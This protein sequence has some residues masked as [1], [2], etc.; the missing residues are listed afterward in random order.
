MRR[1]A[2]GG[3]RELLDRFPAAFFP[4]LGYILVTLSKSTID[5]D[6][7]VRVQYRSVARRI[8]QLLSEDYFQNSDGSCK[9]DD[10]KSGRDSHRSPSQLQQRKTT[11][12]QELNT[13]ELNDFLPLAKRL[14][15]F[16]Q[17]LGLQLRASLT[18][19]SPDIRCDALSFLEALI[20]NP[21]VTHPLV[22]KIVFACVNHGAG[23]KTTTTAILPQPFVGQTDSWESEEHSRKTETTLFLFI[24]ELYSKCL[25]SMTSGSSN[26][27]GRKFF[28]QLYRIGR[29]ALELLK[30][31]QTGL[32]RVDSTKGRQAASGERWAALEDNCAG[33][34]HKD[35]LLNRLGYYNVEECCSFPEQVALNSLFPTGSLN[36]CCQGDNPARSENSNS[37]MQQQPFSHPVKWNSNNTNNNNNLATHSKNKSR[38]VTAVPCVQLVGN[39]VDIW[40][41]IAAHLDQQHDCSRSGTATKPSTEEA[42]ILLQIFSDFSKNSSKKRRPNNYNETE[43]GQAGNSDSDKKK[44]KLV[45]RSDETSLFLFSATRL[46]ILEMILKCLRFLGWKNQGMAEDEFRQVRRFV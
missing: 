30:G 5:V 8:L 35:A 9:G 32:L 42:A 3:I 1:N 15:P 23:I 14:T 22:F 37:F 13:K 17:R 27:G 34:F 7:A 40:A 31:L 4:Q 36:N 24:A 6:P 20:Y 29:I 41:Q 16:A 21:A 43:D 10:R 11:V 2:Y 25:P 44:H 12:Q 19:R 39:L 18:H 38:D 46:Q 45:A 33:D 26:Y 28:T